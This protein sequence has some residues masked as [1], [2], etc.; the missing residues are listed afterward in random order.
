MGSKQG[1][2]AVFAALD[3]V[4]AAPGGV[5]TSDSVLDSIRSDPIDTVSKLP[6]ADTR[7]LV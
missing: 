7:R 2:L 4:V 1:I 3:Q 6:T 5:K